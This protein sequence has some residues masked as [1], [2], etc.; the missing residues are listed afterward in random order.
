MKIEQFL[1]RISYDNQC[2]ETISEGRWQA[3]L[4]HTRKVR[5]VIAQRVFEREIRDDMIREAKLD[6]E[7]D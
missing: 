5:Q 1:N 4:N 3:M 7:K 2:P 6:S